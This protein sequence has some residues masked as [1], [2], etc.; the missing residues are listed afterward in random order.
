MLYRQVKFSEKTPPFRKGGFVRIA[1]ITTSFS[2]GYKPQFT[3]ELF[4]IFNLSTKQS[5]PTY[6][7]E[8]LKGENSEGDFYHLDLSEHISR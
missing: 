6:E 5:V 2:K 1:K 7:L 3:D 8:D 4:R